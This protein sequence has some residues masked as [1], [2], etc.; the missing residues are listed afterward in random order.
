[1]QSRV[2]EYFLMTNGGGA[3]LDDASI[4]AKWLEIAPLI[5]KMAERVGEPNDFPVHPG[6]GL[7]RD[8]KA[9][10]PYQVSHA[11]RMCLMAGVDHLNATKLLL[12]DQNVLPTAA[13]FSLIRGSLE[14]FAAAFW[15]LHHPQH[16][17][18]IQRTLR[19]HAKNFKDQRTALE[20]SGNCDKATMDSRLAKLD[21][22]G[23]PFGLS[24]KDIRAA[25]TSTSAVEYAEQHSSTHPLLPWRACSGYAHG[26]PWVYLG[27]SVQ[28]HFSTA[29]PNVLNVKLTTDKSRVLWPTLSAFHLMTD[30]VRLL[31][32]RSAV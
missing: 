30:V 22:I 15:I 23:S 26:R 5:E 11:V 32:D 24:P 28:E 16:S 31:R 18:R 4:D 17:I 1:M 14:N 9:S 13:L 12:I 10:D 3:P 25:Y 27:M 29:D 20:P 6:S 2:G 19:W 21:A 8:D 7:A